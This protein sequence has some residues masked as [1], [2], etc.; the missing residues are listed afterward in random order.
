MPLYVGFSNPAVRIETDGRKL[1][2]HFRVMVKVAV[3]LTAQKGTLMGGY[4]QLSK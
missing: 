2:P 3:S 1:L 4:P